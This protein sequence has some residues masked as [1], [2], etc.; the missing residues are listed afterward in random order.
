MFGGDNL[1]GKEER[2][3]WKKMEMATESTGG[4]LPCLSFLG[5][6]PVEHHEKIMKFLEKMSGGNSHLLRYLL[7]EFQCDVMLLRDAKMVMRQWQLFQVMW[8]HPN[9]NEVAVKF[10]QEDRFIMNPPEVEEG[11]SQCPRCRSRRTY[12]FTKQTRR[13][14]ESA[15]VFVRCSECSHSFRL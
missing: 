15:T 11:V 12:S 6:E 14:D 4:V 2:M 3:D 13:S 7:Y 8:D 9:F 1:F 5:N 10:Q